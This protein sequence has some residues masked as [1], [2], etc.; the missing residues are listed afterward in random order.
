M[1]KKDQAKPPLE[2]SSDGGTTRSPEKPVDVNDI[3]AS[4]DGKGSLDDHR[5]KALKEVKEL[6][7]GAA[8]KANTDG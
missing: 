3:D 6:G 8:R 2:F 1:T 7:F 4:W 5:Q